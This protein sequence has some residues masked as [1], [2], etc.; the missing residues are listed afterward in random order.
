MRDFSFLK[1]KIIQY[2]EYKDI[3]KYEFY[4]KTGIS[5][6]VLSQKNG[7][8]EENILKFLSYFDDVNLEWLFRDRGEMIAKN[9]KRLSISIAAED[10]EIYKKSDTQYLSYM[11]KLIDWLEQMN[12]ML[13]EENKRL[14]GEKKPDEIDK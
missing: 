13:I 4:Q 10:R 9:E 6:G 5:N 7:L 2:I 3:S 12:I 14:K 11:K 8:S 1:Q